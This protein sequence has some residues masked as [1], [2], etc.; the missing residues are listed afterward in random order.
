MLVL[1]C[2]NNIRFLAARQSSVGKRLG[3]CSKLSC[4]KK[5]ARQARQVNARHGMAWHGKVAR[6]AP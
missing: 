5:T 3:L 1:L 2:A 4:T 6:R